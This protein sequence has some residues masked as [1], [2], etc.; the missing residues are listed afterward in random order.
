[1]V[2]TIHSLN[3]VVGTK[4]SLDKSAHKYKDG[5]FFSSV[6]PRDLGGGHNSEDEEG[7]PGYS[8]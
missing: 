6:G 7:L 3:P 5:G 8:G 2:V 1:M 4:K